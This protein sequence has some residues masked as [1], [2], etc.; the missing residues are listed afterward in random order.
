MKVYLTCTPEFDYE[1]LTEVELILGRTPGELEFIS[2]KPLTT[3]QC[4]L[5]N[6]KM[7]SFETIKNLNFDEFFGLCDT[8][9]INKELPDDAYVVLVTSIKNYKDWFS[10]FKGKKYFYLWG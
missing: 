8:Y 4:S 6:P 7:N 3:A 2:N 10:A 1:V 9:R 5:V